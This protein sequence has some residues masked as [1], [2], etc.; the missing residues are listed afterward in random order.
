MPRSTNGSLKALRTPPTLWPFLRSS[1]K[2]LALEYYEGSRPDATP[3]TRHAAG[4]TPGPDTTAT[5]YGAPAADTSA[6]TR[7]AT[8]A[9]R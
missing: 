9:R 8:T 5:N 3:S 6:A 2:R 4:S 7:A 1:I